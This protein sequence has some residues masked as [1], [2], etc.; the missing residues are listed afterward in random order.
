MPQLRRDPVLVSRRFSAYDDPPGHGSRRDRAPWAA[1]NGNNHAEHDWLA[2]PALPAAYRPGGAEQAD[3]FVAEEL[4]LGLAE[5]VPGGRELLSDWLEKPVETCLPVA[6]KLCNSCF[7]NPI[8]QA[9]N[10][11]F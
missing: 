9:Y 5:P 10:P 7:Q 3:E 11:R 4:L 6:L 2:H 8:K 1:T